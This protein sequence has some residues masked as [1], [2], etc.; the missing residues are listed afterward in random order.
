MLV[1]GAAGD[2]SGSKI[3]LAIDGHGSLSNVKV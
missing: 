2:Y 3:K 1:L